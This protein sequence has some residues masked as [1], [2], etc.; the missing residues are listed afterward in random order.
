[1]RIK[2][3]RI[4]AYKFHNYPNLVFH[5]GKFWQNDFEVKEVAN[6]GSISLIIN[7]V[8]K[9]KIKLLKELRNKN[10]YYKCTIIIDECP[11]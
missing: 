6:N 4:E 10:N 3:T 9:G 8:K 1:M 2:E 11:F 5:S 7:G